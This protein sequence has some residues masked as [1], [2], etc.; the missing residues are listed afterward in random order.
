M[1]TVLSKRA[2][3]SKKYAEHRTAPATCSSPVFLVPGK[4]KKTL[5]NI[6]IRPQFDSGSITSHVDVFRSEALGG[7]ADDQPSGWRPGSHCKRIVGMVRVTFQPTCVI[8]HAFSVWSFFTVFLDILFQSLYEMN[9]KM[10]LLYSSQGEFPLYLSPSQK[11]MMISTL[12][13]GP[14]RGMMHQ[15][16]PACPGSSLYWHLFA[17]VFMFYYPLE[18]YCMKTVWSPNEMIFL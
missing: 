8:T 13:R 17:N 15:S 5:S 10:S 9:Y 4:N 18:E 11:R 14:Q 3:C 1:C 2:P 16:T 7:S 6:L 12:M